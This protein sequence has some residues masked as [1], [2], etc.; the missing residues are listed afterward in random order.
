MDVVRRGVWRHPCK[1]SEESEF[2]QV[3]LYGLL[4]LSKQNQPI[5]CCL[6]L[7]DGSEVDRENFEE[8][9]ECRVFEPFVVIPKRCQVLRFLLVFTLLIHIFPL[10][11]LHM[12]FFFVWTLIFLN[13]CLFFYKSLVIRIWVMLWLTFLMTRIGHLRLWESSISDK[14]PKRRPGQGHCASSLV[15]RLVTHFMTHI[16]NDLYSTGDSPYDSFFYYD[17]YC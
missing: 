8:F 17:S 5:V 15:N 7:V 9:F 6:C 2:C 3:F 4:P 13:I 16:S 14:C 1:G 11:C 12:L 10:A